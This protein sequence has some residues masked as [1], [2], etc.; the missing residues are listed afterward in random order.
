MKPAEIVSIRRALGW[1]QERL[2]IAIGV[3]RTAVT[4]WES[5]KRNPSGSAE[6]LL[7][8][9]GTTAIPATEKKTSRR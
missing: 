8:Q 2:A 9:L 4:L 5:G 6:L 1:T 3:N 7:K